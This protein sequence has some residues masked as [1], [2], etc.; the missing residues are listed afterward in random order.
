VSNPTFTNAP[1][2]LFDD[3]QGRFG[4]LTDLRAAFEI[5]SGA[6]STVR[7]V[8]RWASGRLSS[9]WVPRHLA[10]LI[11][12]RSPIPVN[13][14]PEGTVLALLNGRLLLPDQV[15]RPELGQI[16]VDHEGHAIA[17]LLD[18]A[19][20]MALLEAA[21]PT[22]VAGISGVERVV[23]E[24][25]ALIRRPWDLFASLGRTIAHDGLA[26]RPRLAREPGPA[27]VIGDHPVVIEASARLWPGVVIDAEQGPVIVRGR[28]VIRPH[29]TLAGPCAIGEGST[30]LDHAVIRPNTV[31]GPM[32][33]VAGEL[34]GTIFQ[35]FANKAHEGF[36]GDS[37]VGKWAN[38]GAGTTGSNLLNTY[39]E[40][41]MRLDPESPRER[42]GRQFLGALIGDH[43]KLAIGTRLMTGTVIGTG[44]MVAC[45]APPPPTVSAFAWLTDESRGERRCWRFDRF[46]ETMRTV[47]RRR[48]REPD[49][50]YVSRLR[51]LHRQVSEAE[52]PAN[53]AEQRSP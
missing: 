40:V 9:L 32:C 25:T 13:V 37:Y 2:I 12:A 1:L 47:M 19:G 43:A 18:R 48:D 21:G 28:A 15:P 36:L 49:A 33:K 10:P 14:A 7:R 16:L 39:G 5:R 29:A 17:A 26:E 23:V 31:V 38:I 50:A 24:G 11:A 42:S 22:D 4:P 30:V 27:V 20:A 45:T 8:A 3:G 6:D 51:E 53:A 52:G 46:E 34:A 35:G 44:A 41:V